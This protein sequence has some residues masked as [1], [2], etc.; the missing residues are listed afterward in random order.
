MSPDAK[1]IVE[2]TIAVVAGA[3]SFNGWAVTVFSRSMTI[4][5]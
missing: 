5:Q 4:Y 2:Y 3:G 1:A